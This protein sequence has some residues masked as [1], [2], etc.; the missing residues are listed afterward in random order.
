MTK[1]QSTYIESDERC[2]KESQSHPFAYGYKIRC[3]AVD[4]ENDILKI[5]PK[6]QQN[7]KQT[8]VN[9]DFS[10]FYLPPNDLY[11]KVIPLKDRPDIA[12]IIVAVVDIFL[13]K[14]QFTKSTAYNARTMACTVIRFIEYCWLHNIY[15]LE[16][17]NRSHW[18]TFLQKYVD[19]GWVMALDLEER[20][21]KIDFRDLNL[22]RKR[23]TKNPFEYS[24]QGLLSAMGANLASNHV[25]LTYRRGD[26]SGSVRYTRSEGRPKE[27]VITQVVAQ[28]NNLVDI[29]KEMRA[30]AVAHPNPYLFASSQNATPSNRTE[31]FEP[32]NLASLMAESFRWINEYSPLITNLVQRVYGDLQPYEQEMADE[33]RM[34]LLIEAPETKQLEKMLGV[35]IT[36]VRRVG[37]WSTGIGLLGLMRVMLS[38]CFITLGVF[39]GRRKDEVLSRSIGLYIDSFE[40]LDQELGIFQCEFYCEK[41][42]N[43]YK[44]F[45]IN[46]ISYKALLALKDL[47]QCSWRLARKNGGTEQYGRDLKL[48]CMPP[49]SSE[50]TPVWYDYSSDPGARLLVER[51]TSMTNPPVPNAQ[52]FRR[53]YAVVFHYRFENSDLYSLSQQLD[54]KDLNMVLHYVLDG[55]SREI[56]HQAAKLWGDGGDSRRA[57]AEHAIDLAHEV[58]S[59]SKI[60]FQDDIKEILSGKIPLAGRFSKLVKRFAKKMFGRIKYDD[61]DLRQFSMQIS[62]LF[63]ARGHQTTPFMHGNCNA[64]P[65]K[66]G[67]RCYQKGRISRELASPRVCSDCPYHSLKLNHLQAIKDDLRAQREFFALR[68]AS[69][70]ISKQESESLRATEMLV[71]FYEEKFNS[72]DDEE[73]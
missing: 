48:F 39:N 6:F 49:R 28:L 18:E 2:R 31:N 22:T 24:S 12:R 5:T 27:S 19:G 26:R 41:G 4:F 30:Q 46:E 40:C 3:S 68:P 33:A 70:I 42:S 13:I 47:A 57:R 20:L 66:P 21:A 50:N 43:D 51:S 8:T 61:E 37:D 15:H 9:L 62:K 55:P 67:A 69:S 16:H 73:S 45:F 36:S 53:A 72:N 23:H 59:Y 54:H 25:K 63:I 56:A 7:L 64:G 44:T 71:N 29:P 34:L 14:R 1:R 35:R 60:K 17:V 38:A 32:G 52:M 58:D 65:A 11:P 10:K